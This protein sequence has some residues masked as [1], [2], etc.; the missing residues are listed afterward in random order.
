MAAMRG[1]ACRAARGA[2]LALLCTLAHAGPAAPESMLE[3]SGPQGH[4]GGVLLRA[5]QPAAPVVLIIPG[6]GPTDHDGNNQRGLRA[7]TYRLLAQ[8]LAERGI[9]TLRIDKRGMYSSATAIADAN[10]VSIADYAADVSTWLRLL[11]RQLH[12]PC[13]WLLGHSEGGLVAMVAAQPSAGACGLVLVAAAGRPLG[14]VLR[15]QLKGQSLGAPLQHAAFASIDALEAGR[16]VP[17][18]S[19]PHALLPLFRPQVQGFLISAFSYDP[20][21]LL[22]RYAQPTLI[23]QG[24]RDL[25]VTVED[26]RLLAQAD[27]RA[28][29]LLLADTNHVLKRVTSDDRAANLATYSDANLPLAPG[30]VDGIAAFI[31]GGGAAEPR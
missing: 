29:L 5:V 4:L 14:E 6:S 3:A 15:A 27:P 24:E 9:S 25:Q 16:R 10:A 12:V 26:A 7:E 18:E 11:R 31:R 2:W 17:P 13:A 23:V 21:Q 28:Q 8:G 30:V 22:K 19:L 20:P 1:R